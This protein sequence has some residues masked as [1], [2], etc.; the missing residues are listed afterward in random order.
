MSSKRR[1]RAKSCDKWV[2]AVNRLAREM[3]EKAAS[4][5]PTAWKEQMAADNEKFR[6]VARRKHG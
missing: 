4:L 1:V 6:K 5:H 3:D 2:A